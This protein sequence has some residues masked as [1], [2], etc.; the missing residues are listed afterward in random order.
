MEL[1]P[2]KSIQKKTCH[3]LKLVDISTN[4]FLF[5]N[6]IFNAR[7]VVE[8]S[9]STL[10]SQPLQPPN[11]SKTATLLCRYLCESLPLQPNCLQLCFA[12]TL[13]YNPTVELL[14]HRNTSSG[15]QLCCLS[16]VCLDLPQV[17]D[18]CW[19]CG[20]GCCPHSCLG[21][22]LRFMCNACS[23]KENH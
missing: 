20:V 5:L 18:P 4:R 3:L 17:H 12:Q 23:D 22:C 15:L 19:H 6:V 21:H 8:Y 2:F 16:F 1:P 11:C 14:S 13:V 10:S 7:P 9:C